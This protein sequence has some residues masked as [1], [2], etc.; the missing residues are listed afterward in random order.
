VVGRRLPHAV[1][2]AVAQN[3]IPHRNRAANQSVPARRM[4]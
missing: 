1:G 4:N 3:L 2:H